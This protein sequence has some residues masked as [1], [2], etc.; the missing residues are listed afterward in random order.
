MC[1]MYRDHDPETPYVQSFEHFDSQAFVPYPHSSPSLNTFCVERSLNPNVEAFS[2]DST[3]SYRGSYAFPPPA[4]GGASSR[5][6]EIPGLQA[7]IQ[8]S[9]SG[10]TPACSQRSPS[11]LC[12]PPTP[13]FGPMDPTIAPG[14]GSVGFVKSR[15]YHAD[16]NNAASPGVSPM[17]SPGITPG[18][19]TMSP[20]PTPA[21]SPNLITPGM[22]PHP[23]GQV[24]RT[25]G[26][27]RF[28]MQTMVLPRW[29]GIGPG[30]H[31]ALRRLN[32]KAVRLIC[33]VR[34]GHRLD[35]KIPPSF[36]DLPAHLQAPVLQ[37]LSSGAAWYRRKSPLGGEM[38]QLL[39]VITGEPVLACVP[40]GCKAVYTEQEIEQMT[41]TGR[42]VEVRGGRELGTATD[43]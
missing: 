11:I 26:D 15:D 18:G 40:E 39:D 42:I 28:P 13:S 24:Q 10:G 20:G 27:N 31:G 23:Q 22:A 4:A 12:A 21:F 35:V 25:L 16:W 7:T 3:L 6:V 38:I 29:P 43:A 41:T 32:M 1:V 34:A 2:P 5:R 17:V 30:L 33:E 8:P 9:V 36:F 37:A 19:L 14:R